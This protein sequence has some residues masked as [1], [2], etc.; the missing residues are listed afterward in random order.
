MAVNKIKEKLIELFAANTIEE[1]EENNGERLKQAFG[2]SDSHQLFENIDFNSYYEI[3]KTLS[4]QL[5]TIT[6]ETKGRE[7]VKDCLRWIREERIMKTRKTLKSSP[8]LLEKDFTRK[9]GTNPIK[10]ISTTALRCWKNGKTFSFPTPT[11]IQPKPTA[12]LKI[13]WITFSKAISRITGKK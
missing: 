8:G 13:S 12:I 3:L 11:G 2:I 6:R 1:I 7:Q 4:S 5:E 10:N 9:N